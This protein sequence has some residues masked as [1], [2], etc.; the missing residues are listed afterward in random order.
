MS[1]KRRTATV[2]VCRWSESGGGDPQSYSVPVEEEMDVL[3]VLEYIHDHMDST[4]SFRSSCRRGLCG[5]C[6]MLIDGKLQLACETEPRN[7]MT[8]NPYKRE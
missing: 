1:G 3:N 2:H 6:L 8:I 4:V 7:G 5:G